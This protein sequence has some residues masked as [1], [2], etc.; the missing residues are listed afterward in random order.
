[1]GYETFSGIE[2]NYHENEEIMK[3]YKKCEK[4]KHNSNMLMQ[5]PF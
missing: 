4:K 1:M 5:L 3:V 2:H